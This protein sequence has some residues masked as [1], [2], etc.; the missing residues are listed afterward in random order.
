M[1]KYSILIVD[2]NKN[3][4]T[5]LRILLERYFDTVTLLSSPNMLL[6]TLQT[7]SPD[8]V[9]LDMNF[10][11]EINT[12]NE[13]LYWL[14]EIK[15]YDAELPVV[16]FTAYADID[17]AVQA[18]KQGASDFVV[19]P[20]DNAKLVATLKAACALHESRIE[21]RHLHETFDVLQEELRKDMDICWGTSVVMQDVR[22]MVEKVARTDASILITGENGTGKEVIAREIH[23]LSPRSHEALITV[24]MGAVTR[25]LFESEMFG[26]VKGAFTDAKTNR[27]GKFEAANGGT[28]F[29]DEIGNL[30]Y[31]MQAKLLST[32]QSRQ[33]VK[34]GDNKPIDIDIR[35]ISATNSNLFKAVQNMEFREDLLYRIN[36]I[37]I[38]I[39][40]L[41]E[42]KEDIP[43][44]ADF[45]L[46]KQ[47]RKYHRNMRFS[48][49]AMEKLMSYEW[50]GN[51]RELQHTIEK[52]VILSETNELKV[53][54]FYFN[55]PLQPEITRAV[56]LEDAERIVIQNALRR[57]QGNVAFAAAELGISRPTMYN[58]MRKVYLREDDYRAV[59]K[60]I[61]H[62]NNSD[63]MD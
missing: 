2:D 26:H 30:S 9:L 28:L 40:P 51:I 52:A 14:S 54:D 49:E 53:D 31:S 50:C 33:I 38:E 45:F 8:V 3:V 44:L 1:K 29:L 20:W 63:F 36:T 57:N 56:T 16:L 17:L 21:A 61:Q 39:P 4:L 13:G 27:I 47:S 11:A 15:K 10:S 42:R 7:Q 34:V 46:R 48:D 43:L 6:N 24:D 37:Q 58:K 35:I 19:K 41:R 23:R 32:L 59:H 12:G 62:P 5:T 22:R 18:L 25:S 60:V 55:K